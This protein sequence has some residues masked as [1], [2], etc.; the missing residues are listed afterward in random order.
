M[1]PKIKLRIA[2][3]CGQTRWYPACP[4]SQATATCMERKSFSKRQLDVFKALG[5][6][7]EYTKENA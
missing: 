5:F 1:T 3:H 7:I 4:Y 2:I 6:E